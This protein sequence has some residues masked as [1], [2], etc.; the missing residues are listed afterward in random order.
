MKYDRILKNGNVNYG[1]LA[2]ENKLIFIKTGLGSED[3]EIKNKYF[4]AAVKFREKYGCHVIVASN[5]NDK[6]SHAAEDKKTLLQYMRENG[7]P[8]SELFFLGSSN[9]C[10]KGLEM[11]REGVGFRKMVLV[12]M[13]LMIN[14]HKTLGYISALPETHITAVYGDRDPSFKY[15]PFIDKKFENVN[16]VTCRNADHNFE[17]MTDEFTSLGNILMQ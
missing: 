3:L 6:K 10:V 16:I 2:G 8:Y 17:G 9:G 11:A 14:F 4:E 15:I 1:I 13:P 7:I 5:P 12:N